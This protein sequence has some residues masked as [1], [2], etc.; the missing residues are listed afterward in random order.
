M[1]GKS[2][3]ITLFTIVLFSLTSYAGAWIGSEA[4]GWS[5]IKDDGGKAVSEWVQDQTDGEWYYIGADSIMVRN[6]WIDG[7]YYVGSDGKMLKDTITP[8]GY[9]VGPDGKWINEN[10]GA[11]T[12]SGAAAQ[13][14]NQ[15]SGIPGVYVFNHVSL[16][17]SGKLQDLLFMDMSIG[18]TYLNDELCALVVMQN[19]LNG[20]R[21]EYLHLMRSSNG[22]YWTEASTEATLRF[23]GD[24]A[25]YGFT[26][27]E[28]E[29]IL[30]KK[31]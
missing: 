2:L 28:R 6:Q 29:F 23:E 4:A 1:K 16:E 26:S 11:G 18:V 14:V 3:L 13:S 30:K 17:K 10:A 31:S 8:D 22:T 7:L 20:K 19:K 5:Y 9:K 21:S 27:G 15:P 12:A 25:Y 24:T